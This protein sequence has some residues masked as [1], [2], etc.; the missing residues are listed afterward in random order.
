METTVYMHQNMSYR[1]SYMVKIELRNGSFMII[2]YPV[3]E[4]SPFKERKIRVENGQAYT[5]DILYPEYFE[6][7]DELGFCRKYR[8]I[9]KIYESPEKALLYIPKPFISD[10]EISVNVVIGNGVPEGFINN[11]NLTSKLIKPFFVIGEDYNLEDT[12]Y[13]HYISESSFYKMYCPACNRSFMVGMEGKYIKCPTCGN[14]FSKASLFCKINKT[15]YNKKMFA[16]ISKDFKNHRNKEL[17]AKERKVYKYCNLWNTLF[18]DAK[19]SI[20]YTFYHISIIGN[21]EGVKLSKVKVSFY[22]KDNQYTEEYIL[23]GCIEQRIEGCSRS[24]K[25]LKSGEKETDPFSIINVNSNTVN[26]IGDIIYEDSD[27]FYLFACKYEDVL[28]KIGFLSA[29]KY[30]HKNIDLQSF[31]VI[32]LGIINKYPVIEQ[33]IKMGHANLFFNA[34]DSIVSA[35]SKSNIMNIIESMQEIVNSESR[36]G[37]DALR[38]PLYIGEYLIQKSASYQEYFYWRDLY[39][40]THLSKEQFCNFTESMPYAIVNSTAGIKDI[41]NILKFGYNLTKLFNYIIKT[42]AKIGENANFVIDMLSDYLS[43]SDILQVEP[44]LYPM[45]LKKQHDDISIVFQQKEKADFDRTLHQIGTECEEYVIPD[46]TEMDNVGIPKLFQSLKVVF[47]KSN[48]DFIN[49]GNQQ[50]NC[51]GSYPSKVKR[52]DCVVFF[53]RQKETPEKSFVTAECIPSGLGQCYLSNNRYVK[54]EEI[55]K[56]ARYI[57]NKILKGTS[58]GRINALHRKK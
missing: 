39:E 15:S 51:V 50:H 41:G 36:G 48:A 53:I 55:I 18:G 46:E 21:N 14:G 25:I 20:N 38:I 12:V 1:F 43:M 27:S 35:E 13:D 33:I 2:H 3:L 58:S 28:R 24:Y 49:E 10:K 54:D 7:M 57:A 30:S 42:S 47:P 16:L 5:E 4:Q 56:F 22:L 44:D 40:L 37:K 29:L 9:N 52:G 26:N 19:D 11:K 23:D 31:F 17:H 6:F 8:D 45:D 32:F 34:Y